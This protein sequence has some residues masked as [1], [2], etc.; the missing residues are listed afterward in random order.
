[1][2]DTIFVYLGGLGNIISSCQLHQFLRTDI[3]S[4]LDCMEAMKSTKRTRVSMH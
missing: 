4:P 1:M 3:L 2:G